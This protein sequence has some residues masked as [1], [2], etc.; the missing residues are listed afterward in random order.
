MLSQL[1]K[2]HQ[3]K[4]FSLSSLRTLV[5][6]DDIISLHSHAGISASNVGISKTRGYRFTD[7]IPQS[8][9][10]NVINLMRHLMRFLPRLHLLRLCILALLLLRAK[11]KS[12]H[13]RSYPQWLR[14]AVPQAHVSQGIVCC[15]ASAESV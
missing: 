10:R 6:G 5:V 7:V 3:K 14:T 4:V 1:P 13:M 9:W 2:M 8:S 12:P 11:E 15:C